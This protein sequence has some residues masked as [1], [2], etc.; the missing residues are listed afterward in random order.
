MS[1]FFKTYSLA[2]VISLLFRLDK[3]KFFLWNKKDDRNGVNEQNIHTSHAEKNTHTHHTQRKT[4]THTS[5]LVVN[6]IPFFKSNWP[7]LPIHPFLWE[8]S[9][10]AFFG[11][12]PQTKTPIYKGRV[13]T[14]LVYEF[15]HGHS[16]NEEW[17]RKKGALFQKVLS[18]LHWH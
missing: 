2:E 17:N 5:Q 6:D 14:A 7:I 1:L 16:S 9:K 8:S 18:S 11:I 13:P 10:P 3:T 4:H 12:F 15:F